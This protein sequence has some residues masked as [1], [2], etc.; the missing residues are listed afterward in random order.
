LRNPLTPALSPTNGERE[1]ISRIIAAQETCLR[2]RISN[3][4]GV[5]TDEK[6]TMLLLFAWTAAPYVTHV[7]IDGISRI[8]RAI[9]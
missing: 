4:L 8:W 1:F 5:Q 9:F 2:R 7:T 3:V 6:R